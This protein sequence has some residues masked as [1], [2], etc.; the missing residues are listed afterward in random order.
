MMGM[1]GME[2]LG[3]GM[4]GMGMGMPGMGM[5]GMTAPM[6]PGMM[7]MPRCTMKMEKAQGGMKIACT[8]DDQTA[9]SMMQNLCS[10]LQGGM[11]TCC[12]MMNGMMVCCCNLTMGMCL[13]EMTGKGCTI[14]CT[15]GDAKCG[16]MIQACCDC[17]TTMMKDGCTCCLLMNGTPVCCG[18]V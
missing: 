18:T 16:Q 17:M 10:M 5:G 14:T 13:C 3:M 8:C 9:C 2:R 11:C 4:P 12:L 6:M 15:S 1:M 7:M